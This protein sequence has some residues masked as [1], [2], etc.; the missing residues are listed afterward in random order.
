M[1]KNS[2]ISATLLLTIGA[3]QPALADDLTYVVDESVNY[4]ESCE[5][6]W[7]LL[8]QK[9]PIFSRGLPPYQAVAHFQF[10]ES[11]ATSWTGKSKN[12]PTDFGA[13]TVKS[14]QDVRYMASIDDT[15]TVRY[16]EAPIGFVVATKHVA[17]EGNNRIT[18]L[19]AEH[20][21]VDGY[22]LHESPVSGS[23]QRPKIKIRRFI[24]EVELPRNVW[25]DIALGSDN[26]IE[27]S[28]KVDISKLD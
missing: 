24:G 3:A 19:Y 8:E 4:T 17:L 13:K 23:Y 12:L 18:C 7:Y 14:L 9:E 27:L 16:S 22:T 2:L 1:I 20:S 5:K 21:E 28:M 25:T 15:G 6:G 26:K 11:G 10:Q